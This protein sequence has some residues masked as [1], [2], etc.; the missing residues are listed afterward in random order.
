MCDKPYDHDKTEEFYATSD[1]RPRAD[2]GL[3]LCWK[4]SILF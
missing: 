1:I 2:C 3:A 4:S